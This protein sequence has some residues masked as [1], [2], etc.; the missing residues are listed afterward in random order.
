MHSNVTYFGYSTSIKPRI[1]L[2]PITAITTTTTATVSPPITYVPFI[3][4]HL[5]LV[6]QGQGV[7]NGSDDELSDH[8]SSAS[9]INDDDEESQLSALTPKHSSHSS[10]WSSVDNVEQPSVEQAPNILEIP[11]ER[12][13][14]HSDDADDT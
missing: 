7:D 3:M 12:I 8:Q 10:S 2:E 4:A 1:A 9:Y 13:E 6:W 11:S 14:L 5:M